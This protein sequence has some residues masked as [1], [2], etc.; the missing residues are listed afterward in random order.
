MPDGEDPPLSLSRLW[1]SAVVTQVTFP[2]AIH[3]GLTR[4]NFK[5]KEDPVHHSRV[6]VAVGKPRSFGG[7][8]LRA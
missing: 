1:S 7:W 2:L 5:E 3:E 6:D 4:S 8:D